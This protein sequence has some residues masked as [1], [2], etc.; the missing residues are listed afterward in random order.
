MK[1]SYVLVIRVEKPKTVRV[2]RLGPVDFRQ[3]YYAYVGSALNGLEKRVQRHLR[4]G[5]KLHWHIDYLLENAEVVEVCRIESPVRL[6]CR[7]AKRLSP[8]LESVR[9]FGCSDCRCPSHLFYSG[10]RK[11]LQKAVKEAISLYGTR[12]R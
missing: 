12:C 1:G 11:G 9:G 5:K 3:G 6:E 8:A 7:I 2:G 10:G 4:P